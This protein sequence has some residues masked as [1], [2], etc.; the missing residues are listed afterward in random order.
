MSTLLLKCMRFI[1]PF[2]TQFSTEPIDLGT[3]SVMHT[4]SRTLYSFVDN[5]NSNMRKGVSITGVP[6]LLCL[7]TSDPFF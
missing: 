5:I 3:E 6:G 7:E 1:A 2:Y 4:S